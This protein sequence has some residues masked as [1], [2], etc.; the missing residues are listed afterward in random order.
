M[1]LAARA[2]QPVIRQGVDLRR[3]LK[4][5][6]S[7]KTVF[8]CELADAGVSLFVRGRFKGDELVEV[9]VPKFDVTFLRDDGESAEAF[10][11]RVVAKVLE[12]TT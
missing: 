8:I 1:I 10:S 5:A 11:E 2:A 3:R 7:L 9:R 4:R 6:P 12:L